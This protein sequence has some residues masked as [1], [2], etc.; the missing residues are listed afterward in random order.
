[1]TWAEKLDDLRANLRININRQ[2]ATE[3]AWLELAEAR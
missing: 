3:A 1:M 2:V